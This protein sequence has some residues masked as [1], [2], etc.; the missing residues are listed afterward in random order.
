MEKP[1]LN[2]F[3]L[4]TIL[5]KKGLIQSMSRR[6]FSDYLSHT[7]R[8]NTPSDSVINGTKKTYIQHNMVLYV[9]LKH[10]ME[11]MLVLKNI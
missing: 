11:V 2:A 9:Q 4:G 1:M 8:I 3:K 6:G 5:N 10:L 7:R